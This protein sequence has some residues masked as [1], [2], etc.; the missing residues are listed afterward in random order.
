MVPVVFLVSVIAFVILRISPGDP[1]TIYAGFDVDPEYIAR[2]RASLGLD[3]PLPVQYLAWLGHVVQGDLGVSFASGRPVG[4]LIAD[5]LPRSF[6]LGLVALIVHV[7]LGIIIGVISALKRDSA[8]DFMTTGLATLLIS[9]PS[10]VVALALIVVFSVTLNALPPG[11]YVPLSDDPLGHLRSLIMPALA[12][13][14]GSLALTM[15]HTRSALLEVLDEDYIRTARA[16]GLVERLVIVRHALRNALIPVVTIVGL[17]IG[18]ILE[19]AFIVETIFGWP[20]VGRLAVEGINARDYAVVMG[21]VLVAAISYLVTT[22]ITDMVYARLD[23]RISYT[24]RHH[25]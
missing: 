3:E 11:G 7:G 4:S 12:L 5:A 19:G 23:P 14:S 15:R 13:G 22:L 16:K 9:I 25:E 18:G 20:G 8:L 10:F 21:V 17:Q 6:E 1:V 2:V 24:S